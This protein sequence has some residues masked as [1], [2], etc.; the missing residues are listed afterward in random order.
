MK[1]GTE[2]LIA[3]GIIGFVG[4]LIFGTKKKFEITSKS[5]C[6]N[7]FKRFN[8]IIT[9]HPDKVANLSKAH[10]TIKNK[11]RNYFRTQ[12]NLPIPDF[13]IQGSYKMKTIVEN[14]D[15]KCDV[16]LA[17]IF[18]R[19]PGV[20]IETLQNHI[21]KALNNH[22]SR[23]IMIKINCVRLNYVRDF[24]IDLPIYYS[25][26]NTG[27]MYFGSRG[28][29]WEKSNPKAFIEWFKSKTV[30]KPQLIRIIRYL[31]AWSEY[32][33]HKM[34]KKF[35]SGLALTLWAIEHYQYSSRDDIALFNTCSNIL[36]YLNDNFKFQWSAKMPVEPYDNVLNR[37]SSSQQSGFYDELKH[38]VSLMAEALSSDNQ[39]AAKR[40]WMK[41][42]G[43]RFGV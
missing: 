11:V 39:N 32:N 12:T 5:N 3:L 30:K 26:T 13:Y 9:I 19:N 37:L 15:L 27:N 4:G 23:G 29:Y 17:V 31:K 10:G 20:T 25:D 35:P 14:Q 28:F 24:H 33:K 38:M 2:N 22:T 8:D 40:C 34:G 21:K 1:K 42:F 18:P 36:K 43:S 6:D 41:V 7:F 16:D